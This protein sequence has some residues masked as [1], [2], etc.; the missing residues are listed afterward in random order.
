MISYINLCFPPSSIKTLLSLFQRRQHWGPS[1]PLCWQGH[2]EP[3]TAREGTSP[4]SVPAGYTLS[5]PPSPFSPTPISLPPA[6]WSVCRSGSVCRSL[7]RRGAATTGSERGKQGTCDR[8][9]ALMAP[10]WREGPAL[11][12]RK[13][14]KKKRFLSVKSGQWLETCPEGA[15]SGAQVKSVLSPLLKLRGRNNSAWF[16]FNIC[17]ITNLSYVCRIKNL[18]FSQAAIRRMN[19]QNTVWL[20]YLLKGQM[21]SQN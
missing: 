8:R 10:G 3:H 7:T 14:S 11:L 17:L 1:T 16:F 2:A 20:S 5:P 4:H 13:K 15:A 6:G 12:L 19:I 9:R 18:L 21:Q